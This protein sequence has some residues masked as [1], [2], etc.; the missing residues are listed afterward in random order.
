MFYNQTK[1]DRILNN[2]KALTKLYEIIE[3]QRKVLSA[4]IEHHLNL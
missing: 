4:N 2:K 1:T 3:K